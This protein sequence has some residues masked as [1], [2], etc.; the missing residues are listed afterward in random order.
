MDI[1]NGLLL[2]KAD[3]FC[4]LRD[5]LDADGGCDWTVTEGLDVL[6]MSQRVCG[7]QMGILSWKEL[8]WWLQVWRLFYWN[9]NQFL[10]C[11]FVNIFTNFNFLLNKIQN[12]V[13]QMFQKEIQNVDVPF[14]V[15]WDSIYRPKLIGSDTNASRRKWGMSVIRWICGFTL[16]ERKNAEHRDLLGLEPVSLVIKK[17]RLRWFRHVKCKDNADWVKHCMTIQV[18]GPRLAIYLMKTWWNGVKEDMKSFGLS[19]E[20]A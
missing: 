19:R 7:R 4:Y 8:F 10:I 6:I 20:D 12:Q 17:G 18:E 14:F 15:N 2:V 3:E 5:M 13:Q 1:C 11:K 9:I 16:K